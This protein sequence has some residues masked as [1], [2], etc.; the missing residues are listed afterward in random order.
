MAVG[1]EECER[2][3]QQSDRPQPQSDG[4]GCIRSP[5][6]EVLRRWDHRPERSGIVERRRACGSESRRLRENKTRE[7]HG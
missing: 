3:R 4:I 2:H 5:G 6:K 7:E 1:P